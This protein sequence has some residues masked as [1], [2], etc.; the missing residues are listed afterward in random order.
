MTKQMQINK[1]FWYRVV[2]KYKKNQFQIW[3]Q[4]ETEVGNG[5]LKKSR[6]EREFKSLQYL[7]TAFDAGYVQGGLG[8]YCDVCKDVEVDDIQVWQDKCTRKDFSSEG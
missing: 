1:F 8:W 5:K 6:R 7:F 4:Q 3:L 2:V